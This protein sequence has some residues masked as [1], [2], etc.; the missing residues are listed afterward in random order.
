MNDKLRIED[1]D[2]YENIQV[3]ASHSDKRKGIN[4]SLALFSDISSLGVNTSITLYKDGK[5]VTSFVDN[6]IMFAI[7]C[8]NEL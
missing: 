6:D 3:I 1:F 4:K 8:Y 5:E 2:D 7:E